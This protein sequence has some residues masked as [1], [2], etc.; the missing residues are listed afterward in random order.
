VGIVGLTQS[1]IISG[2]KEGQEIVV[3]QVETAEK[4][5]GGSGGIFPAPGK[6]QR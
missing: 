6:R 1:E 2:I 5:E 3:G 4:T